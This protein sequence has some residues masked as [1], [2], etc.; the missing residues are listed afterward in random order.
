MHFPG[1]TVKSP[2]SDFL[3]RT[4]LNVELDGSN[5]KKHEPNVIEEFINAKR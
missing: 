4:M 3:S 1:L 5:E 2:D